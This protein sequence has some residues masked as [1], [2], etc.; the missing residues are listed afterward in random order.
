[1]SRRKYTTEFKQEAVLLVHLSEQ[2]I[3]AI[4]QNFGINDNMLHRWIKELTEP[5]GTGYCPAVFGNFW[6]LYGSHDGVDF[7]G[8]R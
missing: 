2:S 8:Q 7:A 1:M 5:Q 4:D 3:S 6:N